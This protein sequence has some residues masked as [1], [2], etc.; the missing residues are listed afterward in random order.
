MFA[1]TDSEKKDHG[2]DEKWGRLSRRVL[3]DER[4][5]RIVI[6]IFQSKIYAECEGRAP[7]L[8]IQ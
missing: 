8:V 5:S 3:R 2:S 6:I 4:L 7:E 1:I